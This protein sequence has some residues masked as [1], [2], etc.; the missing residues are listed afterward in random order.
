MALA[1]ENYLLHKLH[2]LSGIIPVGFYMIQHLTL[3][4]FSLA[5]PG[6]FDGV[7]GFFASL[8]GHLLWTLEIVFILLPL[9][10]HAVYGMF[11]VG[12]AEPNYFSRR[13][14]WSENRMYT[15]QRWTGVALFFLLILHV[16]TTTVNAK[17]NGHH[18][19]EFAAWNQKLSANYYAL[20]VIYVI[21]VLA[22]SYHLAYG[23]WNFCIRWGI[24][25]SQ[26]SQDAMQRFAFWMFIVVSGLGIAALLGFLMPRGGV[27]PSS[28]PTSPV[29]VNWEGRV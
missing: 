20:F 25:V 27:A 26:R 18:V 28:E 4:S 13:Y 5:G 21:G 24:T 19:I 1:K 11:I 6:Y 10:F 3:N 15:L 17:I 14:K 12:R 22:A 8:P 23:V 2:S 29:H 7:I 16:V 9:T